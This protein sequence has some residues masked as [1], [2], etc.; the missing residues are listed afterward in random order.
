LIQ[1]YRGGWQIFG[2][3]FSL[4]LGE[5]QGPMASRVFQNS[6]YKW[7]WNPLGLLYMATPKDFRTG[8]DVTVPTPPLRGR[9]WLPNKSSCMS[10][11]R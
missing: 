4:W 9:L 8:N 1:P 3:P 6:R 2:S 7:S 10:R 5:I 11:A